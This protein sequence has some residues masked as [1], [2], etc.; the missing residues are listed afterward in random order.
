MRIGIDLGGTK[1]EAIAL[2]ASGR[3]LARRRVTT[4][5]DYD[6]SIDAIAGLVG[7]IERDAGESGTVGVGI[8]STYQVS[9]TAHADG[10]GTYTAQDEQTQTVP[11]V[12]EVQAVRAEWAVVPTT[13][14]DVYN[15]KLQLTYETDTPVPA[16][17][18]SPTGLAFTKDPAN[19]GLSQLIP[20]QYL[21]A[22]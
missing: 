16:L 19:P 22:V 18:V 3:E 1:I 2:S 11:V 6:P 10:A 8:P 14:Q 21:I 17:A 20:N 13:I 5:R 15:I 7:T 4:P 12:L 9:A